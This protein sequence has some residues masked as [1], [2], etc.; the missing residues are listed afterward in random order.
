MQFLTSLIGG[1]ANLYIN[2]ALA[3]GVVLVLIVLLLWLLKVVF[4]ASSGVVRGRN[5]RLA[6][7]DSL[8]VDGKRQLIIIRRD[9]V[10]HLILTGGPQDL[11]VESGFLPEEPAVAARPVPAIRRQPIAVAGPQRAPAP[12]RAATVEVAPPPSPP[13]TPTPLPA[14]E[15]EPVRASLERLRDFGRPPVQRRPA[16]IRH[17]GLMR[18]VGRLEPTLIPANTDNSTPPQTDSATTIRSGPFG[19]LEDDD[20]RA[21][22]RDSDSETQ[23]DKQR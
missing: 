18:S 15:Q 7:I 13:P 22:G 8:P 11:L 1:S 14:S 17:T 2:S 16:S 20:G 3:L 23:R 4:K 19:G 10:E 9:N 6:V 12:K 21:F 5:K